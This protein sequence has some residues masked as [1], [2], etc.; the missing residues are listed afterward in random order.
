MR[1]WALEA[2]WYWSPVNGEGRDAKDAR[3]MG[4]VMEAERTSVG[5]V[6]FGY[7]WIEPWTPTVPGRP[8]LQSW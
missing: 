7:G 6:N 3:G 1:E 4:S 8:F 2:T 5:N